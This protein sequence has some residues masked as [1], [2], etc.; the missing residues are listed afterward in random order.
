[1]PGLRHFPAVE[2]ELS[3]LSISIPF[4]CGAWDGFCAGVEIC[5]AG[6]LI[7]LHI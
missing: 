2:E 7:V 3:L 4:V 6:G 5:A 1:M